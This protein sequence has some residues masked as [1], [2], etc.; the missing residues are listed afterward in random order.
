VVAPEKSGAKTLMKTWIF[1]AALLAAPATAPNAALA[2]SS[3]LT[4]SAAASLKD[5]L[6]SIQRKYLQSAP[7]VRLRFNFG[8]SGALQRQVEAGAPVDVF[9]AAADKN[10]DALAARGLVEASTRRVLASNRLVLIV[11]RSRRVPI[12]SF[13]DVL[14]SSV[15]HVAVGAPGVP[16]GDR[17]QE[18]FGKLGIWPR[19]QLKAVR[20]RDVRE[21]LA[22]VALG[23]AEAGVVYATDA[24]SS[25]DV[26]VVAVAPPSFHK[27]IRYP[28]AVVAG[29]ANAAQ[30]RRFV[31]FLAGPQAKAILR[32]HKFIVR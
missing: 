26:R 6:A 14:Q 15:A 31:A 20:A 18:V 23:N 5:A 29:S 10:M 24:A 12:K 30:A 32:Q 11:P 17:A 22:Q 4:V 16:A 9:V 27:P 13:R 2:Q 19:V 21:V 8:S 28:V 3:E 25:R 1:L 7:N